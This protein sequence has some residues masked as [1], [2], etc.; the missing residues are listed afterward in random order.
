MNVQ[1]KRGQVKSNEAEPELVLSKREVGKIRRAVAAYQ[2][3]G[4]PKRRRP[5]SGRSRAQ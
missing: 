5:K 3:R 1:T 2:E 4:F